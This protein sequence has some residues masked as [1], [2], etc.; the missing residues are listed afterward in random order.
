MTTL[1]NEGAELKLLL[2]PSGIT[3]CEHDATGRTVSS[4]DRWVLQ[5]DLSGRSFRGAAQRVQIT[6][7]GVELR[8]R[9]TADQPLPPNGA[10]LTFSI[11][12]H[13]GACLIP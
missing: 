5:G 7:A 8:F 4:P 12:P 1:G 2:R 3:I 6:V 13:R 9:L 10:S 11:D